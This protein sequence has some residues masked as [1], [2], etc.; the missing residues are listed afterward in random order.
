M[1]MLGDKYKLEREEKRKKAVSL[2][3]KD[4]EKAPEDHDWSDTPLFKEYHNGLTELASLMKAGFA[5]LML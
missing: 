3:I 2:A 1:P 4:I 5:L